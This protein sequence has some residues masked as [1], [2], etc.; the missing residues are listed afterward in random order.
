MFE[1]DDPET[2][3]TKTEPSDGT[4]VALKSLYFGGT[5]DHLVEMGF[6]QKEAT[7][8]EEARFSVDTGTDVFEAAVALGRDFVTHHNI[9]SA[10]SGRETGVL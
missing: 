3:D 2:S 8:G 5:L 4:G 10:D 9:I 1:D 7:G 6:L